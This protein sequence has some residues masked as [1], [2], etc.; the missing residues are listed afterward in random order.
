VHRGVEPTGPS[1]SGNGEPT[2]TVGHKGASRSLRYLPAVQRLGRQV[3]LW[4]GGAAAGTAAAALSLVLHTQIA[5]AIRSIAGRVTT[6]RALELLLAL[7]FGVALWSFARG[8]HRVDRL[9]SELATR[10]WG[11]PSVVRRACAR[12]P[13]EIALPVLVG[14]AAGIWFALDRAATVPR[15]FGDELTYSELAKQIARGDGVGIDALRQGGYGPL[16]PLLISPAYA[17]AHDGAAAFTAVKSINALLMA[18]AAVPTYFLA[19]RLV[20]RGWALLVAAFAVSVPAMSYSALVMTEAAFYP[21]FLM[22]ALLLTRVLERSTVG[23]QLAAVAGVLVLCAVRVQAVALVGALVTAVILEGALRR[24]LGPLVRRFGVTWLVLALAGAAALAAARGSPHRVLGAYGVLVRGYDPLSVVKW[25]VWN[26]AAL[27]LGIGIVALTAFPLALAA[28]LRRGVPV[29]LR[30]VA[31]V[32]LSTTLWLLASVAVLSSSPYGL[33]RLHERN[34]FYVTP[35]IV[36][37]VAHLFC[38]RARRPIML[39]VASAVAATI[40]PA[41]LPARFVFATS[42]VDVPGLVPWQTLAYNRGLGM[43][44][45]SRLI[46][47]VAAL[48]A[49]ATLRARSAFPLVASLVLVFGTIDA[50]VDYRAPLT[51]SQ[52]SELSWIDHALRPSARATLVYVHLPPVACPQRLHGLA[53]PQL[54]VWTEFFNTRIDHVVQLFGTNAQRYAASPTITLSAD[55]ILRQ[56]GSALAPRYVVIDSRVPIEGRRLARLSVDSVR[57]AWEGH[58]TGALTLWEAAQP[59]QVVEPLLLQRSAR[60]TLACSH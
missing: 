23:R 29:P 30:A 44:P 34:L 24:Q 9:L 11:R 37:C 31:V 56:H 32:A 50:Q 39:A 10:A 14:V 48:A 6:V 1:R 53:Q 47:A 27:E 8:D 20:S 58:P 7:A 33:E 43:I 4:T 36:A 41:V 42:S 40:L 60:R 54:A 21:G 28:L 55:G 25:V 35:L 49:I 22:V 19:K 2:R 13:S 45:P 18:L 38:E 16:Y 26:T 59:L 15:V 5:S 52:T 3:A 46:V 51:R 17:L 12:V 57:T